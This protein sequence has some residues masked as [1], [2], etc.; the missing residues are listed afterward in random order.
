MRTILS[1]KHPLTLK[2]V[3]S[4]ANLFVTVNIA[5]AQTTRNAGNGQVPMVGTEASFRRSL[6]STHTAA[7]NAVY[8]GSSEE[9]GGANGYPNVPPRVIFPLAAPS[10]NLNLN[11]TV[12]RSPGRELDR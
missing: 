2:N 10:R 4:F 3:N 5:T 9:T 7:N 12:V 11:G 8:F 6:P 1:Q